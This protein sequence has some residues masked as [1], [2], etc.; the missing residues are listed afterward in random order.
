MG[1]LLAVAQQ[2][3]ANIGVNRIPRPQ[4]KIG[5]VSLTIITIILISL[6]ALFYLAQSN[7]KAVKSYNVKALEERKTELI[8]STEKLELEAARLNSIKK[9]SESQAASQMVPQTD[10]TYVK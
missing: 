5:S 4:I 7:Q 3:N 2:N 9:I 6:L 8:T 1:R 10:I